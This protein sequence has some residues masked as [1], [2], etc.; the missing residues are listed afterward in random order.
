MWHS[1]T[2]YANTVWQCNKKFAKKEFC[3]TPHLKEESLKNAFVEVFNSLIKNR[4]EII[5][6][7]EEI[8]LNL[9]DFR[10]QETENSKIDE[11]GSVVEAGLEKLITG[12]ARKAIDQTEYNRRYNILASS[13]NDLQKR[14]QELNSEI[15]RCKAK[16]NHIEA[17]IIIRKIC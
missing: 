16:H 5:S 3:T 11:E 13:Y 14:R 2:K 10:K 15:A 4:D 17:F 9:T 12:N 7:L 6:N 1:T 8:V